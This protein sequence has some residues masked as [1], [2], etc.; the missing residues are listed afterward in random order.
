MAQ[1]GYTPVPDLTHF[2]SMSLYSPGQDQLSLQP[3][4]WAVAV[5]AKFNPVCQL[6]VTYRDVGYTLGTQVFQPQ[7][8]D[9]FV[10]IPLDV[11]SNLSGIAVQV[12]DAGAPGPGF[13][14]CGYEYRF[15]RRS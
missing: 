2:G 1:N 7:Q 14:Q 12:R 9:G 8:A 15:Y 5:L 6:A 13:R 10:F 11:S 4:T 3:G